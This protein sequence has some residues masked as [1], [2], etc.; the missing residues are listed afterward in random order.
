MRLAGNAGCK[1]SPSR[2]HRTTLSGCS[3][4]T[5]I[6]TIRKNLL[7]SNISSRRPH[8]M[9]N[10]GPLR[11]EIGLPVWGTS[12]NFNRFRVLASLLQRRRSPEANQTLHDLWPSPGLVHYIYIFGGF[13]PLTEFC[14]VQNSPCVKVLHSPILAALL[15]DTPPAGLSQ[16]LRRGTRNGITELSQTAPPI[17]GWAAITLGIGPHSSYTYVR[18]LLEFACQIWSPK[19]R[20]LIDKMESVQRFF[21]RLAATLRWFTAGGAIRIALRQLSQTWILRHYD[22]IDDVITGKL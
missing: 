22:V 8:N 9:A 4:A 16:T 20:Y 13:C 17:F 18:P 10:F 1:K 7:N 6:S 11:A 15:H 2:H 21:T 3:F 5:H 12:A 14:Y 19:Y